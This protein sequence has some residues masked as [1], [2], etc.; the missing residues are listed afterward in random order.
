MCRS[1]VVVATTQR[2]QNSK[3]TNE[4]FYRQSTVLTHLHGSRHRACDDSSCV[5]HRRLAPL[6]CSA[7]RAYLNVQTHQGRVQQLIGRI[8]RTI[9]TAYVRQVSCNLDNFYP[10]P[11]SRTKRQR[12]P[13]IHYVV[14]RLP[15]I[16]AL[17]AKDES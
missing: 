13:A 17:L 11:C 1:K 4:F 6:K 12:L 15:A 7:Q 3:F 9:G 14:Y 5:L 10:Y 16:T 8:G 2:A